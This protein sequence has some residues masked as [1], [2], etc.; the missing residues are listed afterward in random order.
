[1]KGT[2]KSGVNKG[3]LRSAVAAENYYK[4]HTTSGDTVLN[5]GVLKEIMDGNTLKNRNFIKTPVSD[6]IDKER[7]LVGPYK[8]VEE[9]LEKKGYLVNDARSI[10]SNVVNDSVKSIAFAR[11]FGTNGELLTPLMQQIKTKYLNSNLA[12]EK[13]TSA[14]AQEI[15]LVSDSID[16]YF[17]RYGKAMTGA[18]K[19][20]ASL[21]ATLGNLIVWFQL[22]GQLKWDFIPFLSQCILSHC[23]Y[24]Q[25]SFPLSVL[26][27]CI[28]SNI[29]E[30]RVDIYKAHVL[31]RTIFIIR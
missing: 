1:M 7:A 2:I 17:D 24:L 31:M 21:L 16:A 19:S 23:E 26:F 22:N 30:S 8:L 6:H 20:S 25:H 11:Q 14:A 4:G 13:A 12:K 28:T 15:K 9:V 29:N 10:L 3:K 27:Y 5:A 18:A